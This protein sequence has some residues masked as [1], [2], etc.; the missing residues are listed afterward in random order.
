M[1]RLSLSAICL[2][3]IVSC[4]KCVFYLYCQVCYLSALSFVFNW[5]VYFLRALLFAFHGFVVYLFSFC[6]R[7]IPFY[8]YSLSA[9]FLVITMTRFCGRVEYWQP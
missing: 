7:V 5:Y 9:L 8:L 4:I 1:F 6:F 3:F 2:P